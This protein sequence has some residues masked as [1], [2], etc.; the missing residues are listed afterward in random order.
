MT[1]GED[2]WLRSLSAEQKIYGPLSI[3]GGI[4]ETS[5]GTLDKTIKA[6]FKKT[7]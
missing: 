7:W 2:K 1:S 3:A 4:A 6:G 5:S